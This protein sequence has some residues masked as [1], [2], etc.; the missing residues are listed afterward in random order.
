MARGGEGAEG[1]EEGEGGE[2]EAG[3]QELVA[4]RPDDL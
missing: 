3:A 4:R 1:G 2:A